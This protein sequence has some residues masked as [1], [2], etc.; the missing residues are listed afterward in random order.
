[1]EYEVINIKTALDPNP[2]IGGLSFVEGEKDIPF[3]MRRIYFIY[4]T[5]AGIHRG[6]HAH[7]QNWQLLFCPYGKIDI[8]LDSGT[9]RETVTLDKPSKGLILHPGL[10]REMVWRQSDSVLCVA[11]SEYYDPND[12]IRNYDDFL[13]YVR[14][15]E[16]K[17]G[18]NAVMA[19]ENK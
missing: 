8:I 9:E 7:K 3:Q 13:T 1:M 14:S 12:Y 17:N 4:Q 16:E 10:W 6:F 19:G 2:D 15:K 11:A 5:Q 18:A